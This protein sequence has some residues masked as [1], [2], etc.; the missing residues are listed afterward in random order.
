MFMS[1]ALCPVYLQ[2]LNICSPL[3]RRL[4]NGATPSCHPTHRKVIAVQPASIPTTPC[5][6]DGAQEATWLPGT[7]GP[8]DLLVLSTKQQFLSK[9]ITLFMGVFLKVNLK[10]EMRR[11]AI[12]VTLFFLFKRNSF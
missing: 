9:R 2:A 7:A 10:F 12:V 1:L 8:G 6:R 11:K 4:T 5:L 3:S